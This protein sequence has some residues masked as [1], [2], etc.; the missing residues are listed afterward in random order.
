M[1]SSHTFQCHKRLRHHQGTRTHHLVH[2]AQRLHDS[3][4]VG[5]GNDGG[6]LV[7]RGVAVAGDTYDDSITKR[8]ALAVGP[9]GIL[10]Y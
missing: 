9:R 7:A 3:H 1:M 5:L 8:G 2:I 4:T 10:Y 6:A